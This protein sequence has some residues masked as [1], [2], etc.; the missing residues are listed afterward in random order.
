MIYRV[1]NNSRTPRWRVYEE[2]GAKK[3]FGEI[4]DI[5]IGEL[6]RFKEEGQKHSMETRYRE[7]YSRRTGTVPNSPKHK[8]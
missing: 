8:G 6:E 2:E 1:L 3:H 7:N 4:K 5:R